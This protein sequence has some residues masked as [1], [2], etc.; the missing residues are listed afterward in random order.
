MKSANPPR[1]AVW[2]LEH[3]GSEVNLEAL[4]GD[5]LEDY[6]QGRSN[7]WYWR[8][9]L[10]ALA[11]RK[12]L[13]MLI[14]GICLAWFLSSPSSWRNTPVL[15][16]PLDMAVFA[17]IF[18]AGI[19]LPGMMRG[20]LRAL[21]VLFIAAVFLLLYHYN[22]ALADHYLIWG[23]ILVFNL[24]SHRKRSPPPLFKVTFREL[25]R[26]DTSEERRRLIASLERTM[27]HEADPELRQAYAQ[28]IAALRSNEPAAPTKATV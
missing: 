27:A 17:A 5:L 12:H 4:A 10:A 2:M 3:F 25:L 15:S 9:V 8:Q 13:F 1:L 18:W 22:F 11:W 21:L 24:A 19:L 6:A 28:S 20:A 14:V 23:L 16:R 26:G 7:A